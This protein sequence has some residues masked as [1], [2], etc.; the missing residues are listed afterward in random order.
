MSAQEENVVPA[1]P[2][3]RRRLAEKGLDYRIVDMDAD[4]EAEGFI[5]ADARGFLDEEPTEKAVAQSR[6]TTR[7]RR[8][9]GVYD[10]DAG[11]LPIATVNSWVTPM[12]M[13]GGE[14]DLWAI[15]SVTVSATHR[16]RGI[17]RA[18]LEGELRAAASAGVALAGLTATEA[19]IYGRYGFAPAIPVSRLTVDTARAGWVGAPVTGRIVYTDPATLAH[20]LESLHEQ[21]RALRAGQIA[22]WPG[23]WQGM[24]GLL[25]G[26]KE[27]AS[28]RGVRYL[29]AEGTVR[30]AMAYTVA[31]LPG[32]SRAE[33]KIRILQSTTDEAQRAL[34]QFAVQHDLISRVSVDLRPID[35]AL[36]WLV[37]DHRAVTDEV[38]DHGWL[39]ILDVPAAL[40]AR[41][42]RA[43]LDVVLRVEDSLGFADGTWRVLIDGDGR[44][45]VQ[46]SEEEPTVRMSVLELSAM[47]V[48]GVRA[49]QLA[50]AGRIQAESGQA[51]ALDDAFRTEHAPLL[52]IW[53]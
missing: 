45:R 1:D 33:L 51:A 16:R 19:T 26:D 17:A 2:E 43:P 53:Y 52:G 29:D 32:G 23:R 14:I 28:V 31:P 18:L 34:W 35:D 49:T 42:Y 39:R 36:T 21:A 4:A 7:L 46:P 30:G 10:T 37:A 3:A 11:S 9:I 5:R 22:A 27:A 25:E 44:A 50:A 40:Q 20:D 48:G 41:T 8:N 38:H 6:E 13:P 12:T 24:A 47:L 15:S